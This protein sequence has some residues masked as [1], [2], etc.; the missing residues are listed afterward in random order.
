MKKILSLGSVVFILTVFFIVSCSSNEGGVNV[1]RIDSQD[2]ICEQV[3]VD[4]NQMVEYIFDRILTQT[5]DSRSIVIPEPD[6]NDPIGPIKPIKPIRFELEALEAINCLA[7]PAKEKVEIR[8]YLI[9]SCD[10]VRMGLIDTTNTF[11][12]SLT[13]RLREAEIC[14]MFN[15]DDFDLVSLNHR[16]NDIRVSVEKMQNKTERQILLM[17][18]SIAENTFQYWHANF[19]RICDSLGVVIP[20]L[21]TKPFSNS[22]VSLNCS[23]TRGWL[24]LNWKQA[25]TE[26]FKAGI[27]A[28]IGYFGRGFWCGGPFA[29]KA[30]AAIVAGTAAVASVSDLITQLALGSGYSVSLINEF[31]NYTYK[32]TYDIAFSEFLG[33]SLVVSKPFVLEIEPN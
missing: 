1:D 23:M 9:K 15:D 16:L 5:S 26:D 33:N 25:G 8:N 18:L 32:D 30:G 10:S 4:H 2:A 11:S 7:I 12:P 22:S 31:V 14:Q 29:W 17:G 20:P 3:G 28:A 19:D 24:G 13:Y 27:G 6:P 21:V